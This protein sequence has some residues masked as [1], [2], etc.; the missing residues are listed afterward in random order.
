MGQPTESVGTTGSVNRGSLSTESSVSQ[1][2]QQDGAANRVVSVTSVTG[3]A[4]AR[5]S[6]AG[7]GRATGGGCAGTVLRQ[8]TVRGALAAAR[9][10]MRLDQWLGPVAWTSGSHRGVRV[11]VRP[12][13][14]TV[15]RAVALQLGAGGVLQGVCDSVVRVCS[16][17]RAGARRRGLGLG[18][19]QERRRSRRRGG[20]AE[21]RRGGCGCGCYGTIVM[22]T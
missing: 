14:L 10:W 5:P 17:A 9:A 4:A 2:E 3:R 7:A 18:L 16:A 11:R 13:G 12:V 22:V 8:S 19:A 6:A 1:G 15:G 20:E 21:R